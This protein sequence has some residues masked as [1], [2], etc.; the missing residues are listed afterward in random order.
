[1]ATWMAPVG[2]SFWRGRQYQHSFALHKGLAGL[3]VDLEDVHR[4]HVD[5]H[6]AALVG[7][8]LVEIHGDGGLTE[9]GDA[10]G[11]NAMGFSWGQT[12]AA[13]FS[14]GAFG[15]TRSRS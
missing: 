1:M 6:G 8:A 12:V 7:N 2:Q 10:A 4:A 5:A 13:A 14:A 3:G 15:A 11:W 9:L